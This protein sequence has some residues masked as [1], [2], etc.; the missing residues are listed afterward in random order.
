VKGILD[1]G[2]GMGDPN[3]VGPEALEALADAGAAVARGGTSGE[4]IESV[5]RAAAEATSAD[6]ALARVLEPGGDSLGVRG[7]VSLS[8]LL[9]AEVAG[10]PLAVGDV[11]TSA[12]DDLRRA[13]A[14]VRLAAERIGARHL[15]QVPV[16]LGDEVHGSVELYRR[17]EP[18]EPAAPALARL[19]AAQLGLALRAYGED[20]E[21][22]DGASREDPVLR[23]AGDALAAG[24]DETRAAEQIVRLAA[25]AVEAETALLWRVEPD[26]APILVAAQAAQDEGDF[27]EAE[28]LAT[29]TLAERQPIRFDTIGEKRA[30]A[31]TLG[32]PRIGLL[33]LV[34][35]V[36][37]EPPQERMQQ[38]AGFGV[39][40]AHAL[41]ATSRSR[42]LALE[43]ERNR[44]LLAVVGQAIAQLSLAH[45]L[46]TAIDRVS[47]LLGAERAAIYL[48]EADRV[49]SASE[50]GLAGPH[51]L[52]GERLLELAPA[53][54]AGGTLVIRDATKE[55]RLASVADAVQESGIEGA[56]AVPLALHG[57]VIG[58][59]AVYLPR[60]SS[61]GENETE[62]LAALAAQL[63]VAVEN[64]R[65]HE[66][67]KRLSAERERA[68]AAERHTARRLAALYEISNAFAETLSLDTTLAAVA[69]TIVGLLDVDAAV[70]RMPDPRRE[71]L[72]PRAVHVADQRLAEPV[73]TLLGRPQPFENLPI[74]AVFRSRRPIVLD[75][76]TAA[77]AGGVGPLLVPFL[78][79]GST[80]AVVPLAT[81]A[82][83]IAS[84]TLL[85]F[86]PDRQITTETVEAARE[87]GA[88]AALAI[89]NARL[90][91]Q[92][93]HFAD[94]MLGSILPRVRP[95]VAGLDIGEVYVPSA[96]VEVGGDLYDYI[97]LPDGRLAVVLGDVTGHGVDAAA[98]MAM[99]KF[100]FRS[101]AR[102]HPEP[103]EFLAFANDVV[104]GELAQGKF[105][106]M[107]YLTIDPGTGAVACASAGHPAPRLVRAGGRVDAIEAHGLALGVE[108]EQRY[109]E[110]R[111]QLE[112]GDA[113]ALFT[114][115]VIET[116]LGTE[117]YGLER[118]DE[119][120]SRRRAVKAED[121]AASVIASA[122]RFAG[123]LL[124]D[125][126]VVV[127]KR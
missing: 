64:A 88:Q 82:E 99:A 83:V 117:M 112:P 93:M 77:E 45:T 74:Q 81:P 87:I 50:R 24:T 78:E 85:S 31:I 63:A 3:R 26:G 47:E 116:R 123:E 122:R 6:A 58:L 34:F 52:V 103:G 90:Y 89:D 27:Q 115:G 67:A 37:T 18:F 38:L 57:E 55:P 39:R 53:S 106:T 102:E 98:D 23:T 46:E 56:V 61:L 60:S 71:L 70:I 44:A 21:S 94:T 121:L 109:E 59:L 92:Q 42:R 91:Q 65:L 30:V 120:L 20:R 2:P 1:T 16:V 100:V 114:D 110:V 66:Q 14:P 33:Q 28:S 84:V 118:L 126:A 5:L 107:V 48:R 104:V 111:E 9:T 69:R 125:C 113:V 62:L 40:V 7:V 80:A 79:Q 76:A 54:R 95:P 124:D 4:L 72:L 43:L 36:G 11:P 35:P 17:E 108:P 86:D 101:L 25:E 10:A 105:I 49:V 19:A 127:I 32:E 119:V 75:A 68:L 51:A 15:L 97:A 12:L 96:R 29:L 13:S 8:E 73:K 22:A 41:R